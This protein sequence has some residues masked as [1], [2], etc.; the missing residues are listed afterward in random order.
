M[1]PDDD[2]VCIGGWQG[3]ISDTGDDGIVE[4]FWDSVTLRQVPDEYIRQSEAE[5][6]D[7]SK[8]CLSV[9]E[10]QSARPRDSEAQAVAALEEI[11]NTAQWM[12]M[13]KQGERITKVLADA[14]DAEDEIEIWNRHLTRV[15]VFPFEAKVSEV[16]ERGP[17]DD[18]D[19]VKV[20]GIAEADD[21]YGILVDVKYGRRHFVL[22]LCDLTV[23]DRKSANHTPVHDY[24]VWFANR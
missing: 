3:R 17:L 6:L 8:M 18:G 7:W 9:D 19:L 4:I 12:D 20:H 14:Q 21:L 10:I 22:P 24:C 16:Q 11:E 2:S 13:G 23:R 1:C 5:G 15:L